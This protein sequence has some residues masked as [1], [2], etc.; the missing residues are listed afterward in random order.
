MA[1][2]IRGM[3]EL[4]AQ[5]ASLQPKQIKR[6]LVKATGDAMDPVLEAARAAAP[7]RDPS[8]GLKKTYKGRRVAP[9]FLARNIEKKAVVAKDGSKVTAMVGPTNE[10]FYG[11]AFVEI[12]TSRQP[13]QPFLV[14]ALERN[15]DTV[16]SRLKDRLGE[17]IDRT[18]K[19]NA[20]G[21]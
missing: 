12:G 14:P 2:G 8:D 16:V 21:T 20:R 15:Q 3:R 11:T 4:Q 10:A 19:R 1:S 5:L 17:I 6:A 9:G 7:Q 18:V 13:A